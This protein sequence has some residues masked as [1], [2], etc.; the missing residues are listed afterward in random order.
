MPSHFLTTFKHSEPTAKDIE[1][2]VSWAMRSSE[3]TL[4]GYIDSIDQDPLEEKKK[5]EEEE[6]T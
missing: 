3:E 4:Q 5:K 1:K 6:K 2:F